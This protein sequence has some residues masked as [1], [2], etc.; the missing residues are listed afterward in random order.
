[1]CGRAM[2]RQC[3]R[4]LRWTPCAGGVSSLTGSTANQWQCRPP[5]PWNSSL[6]GRLASSDSDTHCLEPVRELARNGKIAAPA[7]GHDQPC[8][9]TTPGLNVLAA[10]GE[11]G[12]IGLADGDTIPANFHR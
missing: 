4:R 9:Q 2:V 5:L 7:I 11:D 8:T 3:W 6:R 12:G 1:M 10:V